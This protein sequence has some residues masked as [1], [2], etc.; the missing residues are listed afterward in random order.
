[1]TAPVTIHEKILLDRIQDLLETNN[2]YLERARNA[3]AD[4]DSLRRALL[5]SAQVAS[6]LAMEIMRLQDKG[7][8]LPCENQPA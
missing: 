6:A 1:M 7:G 3:E 4:R 8:A 5:A 2:R